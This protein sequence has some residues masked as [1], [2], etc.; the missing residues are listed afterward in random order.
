MPLPHSAFSA[1]LSRFRPL[2]SGIF[3]SLRKPVNP[4]RPNGPQMLTLYGSVLRVGQIF[5]ACHICWKYFYCLQWTQG[6]SMVPTIPQPRT[7]APMILV[8]R[9]YRRGRDV[10]V[11]DIV[12]FTHP[13]QPE[14][15]G[16]KRIVGMP[17]DLVC[18]VSPGKNDD[19]EGDGEVVKSE[20]REE[21]IEVPEGHCWVV[22]D[23]ME[24]SRDSRLF[25][26][27]PLALV[28]GKILGLWLPWS[29]WKWFSDPLVDTTNSKPR[30]IVLP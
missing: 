20:I 24:W 4:N 12:I 25:G 23:N 6:I 8:S 3:P 16:A 13:I 22:G 21:M 2:R 29:T 26:P 15:M 14:T 17:G 28:K 27:L 9:L 1:L 11:G 10:K 18:V 5:L 19:D 7:G 30:T